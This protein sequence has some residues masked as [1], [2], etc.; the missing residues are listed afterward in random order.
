MISTKSTDTAGDVVKRLKDAAS[1]KN[2]EAAIKRKEATEKRAAADRKRQE[3]IDKRAAANTMKMDADAKKAQAQNT[4]DTMLGDITDVK[5]KKKAQLLADAAIAGVAVTKVKASFIAANVTAACDDAYLKLGIISDLGTCDLSNAVSGRRHILANTA[6]LVKILLSSAEVNQLDIDAALTSLSAAG[7]TA[8]TTE[9]DALVL[10]S[11]IPGINSAILTTLRS[12]ATAAATSFATAGTAET[13]AAATERLATAFETDAAA[14]EKAAVDLATEATNLDNE[15]TAAAGLVPPPASSPPPPKVSTLPPITPPPSSSSSS[16]I[17]AIVGALVGLGLIGPTTV[18]SIMFFFFKPHLRRKLLRYGFKRLANLLVPDLEGDVRLMSVKMEQLESFLAKQKLPRLQDVTPEMSE[19][20]ITL[21]DA[22][23]LGSGGYGDVFKGTHR[24]VPVAVKAMFC[25]KKGSDAAATK[26]PAA[27]VKMMRREA[28]IMCSLNHPNILRVFG[29]VPDRGWIIM[30]LCEG[31]SLSDV[32]RDPDET[33]LGDAEMARVAAETATG[34]AYLHM[35]DVAIV[36]GD[37]KAGNVLLTKNRAVRICDFGMSE[38]KDRSKT[39]SVAAAG[40]SLGG[41]AMT[42]AW[43]APELFKDQPKS[44][45]TDVYALGLTLWEIY[46]RRQPFGNMPEA[47]VVNQ[48]LSGERPNFTSQTPAAVRELATACWSKEPKKRP[49]AAKLAFILTTLSSKI[50]RAS[51]V[52]A[53]ASCE[54][55]STT[56][57]STVVVAFDPAFV[58]PFCHSSNALK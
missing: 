10:L 2:E 6:Y 12:E 15:A 1:A 49:T 56:T 28:T 3:A 9:E 21:D 8:E 33:W 17:A 50:R 20:D 29:I 5:K 11:T 45:A 19:S 32:L 40:A 26:V 38:A 30:E 53:A 58:A 41:A 51:I 47:A 37:M 36:H 23:V 18:F 35:R 48:V 57:T 39:M 13:D 27:V 55:V 54:S 25:G 16:P 46:E 44:Y 52:P 31:G 42:V 43:S 4:R 14:A 7:V 24:G 22:N 34:I